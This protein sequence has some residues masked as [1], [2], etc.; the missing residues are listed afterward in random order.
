VSEPIICGLMIPTSW[1]SFR[2]RRA[3]EESA[4]ASG[5]FFAKE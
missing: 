4:V 3:G 5:E 1:P 2:S